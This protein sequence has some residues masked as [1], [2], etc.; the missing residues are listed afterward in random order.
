MHSTIRSIYLAPVTCYY[1]LARIHFGPLATL[2]ARDVTAPVK[3]A[4]ALPCLCVLV[5]VVASATAQQLAGV[6]SLARTVTTA[7]VCAHRP[8]R[9]VTLTVVR[10]LFEKNQITTPGFLIRPLGSP[11]L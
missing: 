9:R 4:V 1:S 7:V 8:C 2:L 6:Q 10:R 5:S 3:L 11:Q